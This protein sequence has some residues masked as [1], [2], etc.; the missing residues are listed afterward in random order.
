MKKRILCFGDSNTW[1]Y[2]PG[3]GQRY[4]ED[5]RWTGRL[6]QLLGEGYTVIEEGLSGRTTVYDNL[7]APVRN[8]SDQLYACLLSQKPLDLMIVML[9]TNDLNFTT[10]FGAADGIRRL[11]VITRHANVKS[12]ERTHVFRDVERILLVAP[13]H[14]S[15]TIKNMN[16]P[17]RLKTAA[18]RS[19]LFAEAYEKLAYETGVDFLD[20][21][22]YAQAGEADGIHLDENGHMALATALA[23]KVLEIL[24]RETEKQTILPDY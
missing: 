14:I 9:G 4:S 6:Q 22:L 7:Y 24:N 21:A 15:Q 10:A 18:D 5:I 8:G 16:V 3:I 1:G 13:I 17:K 11:L 12:G 23:P 19:L 20:A 2:I